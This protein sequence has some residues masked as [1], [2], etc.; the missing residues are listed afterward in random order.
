M[1]RHHGKTIWFT[2]L[3][4]SGKSTISSRLETILESRGVP[5][6]LLDGDLL[7]SGLNRDLGFSAK[8]RAENIRRAGETAKILSDAG[9]TVL[10]AFITPMEALRQAVRGLFNP[11]TFVEVFLSC[12]ISVCEQRDPKGLYSLAR[13][14]KIPEFTGISSPFEPPVN[15]DLVVPTGEQTLE[16]SAGCILDF[17]EKRFSDLRPLSIQARP[18]RS[19]EKRVLVIGLDSVP[20]SLVFGDAGKSLPNLSALVDHGMS[21]TLKSTDPPITVPAWSTMTTG[22]D[23]GELGLYGFRNR[24]SHDYS[25]MGI[26]DATDVEAPRVWDYLE[27]AGN[28]SILVGIPQTYP[29][30]P[31]NGITVCGP[32]IPEHSSTFTFPADLGEKLGGFIGGDY[33]HDLKDFRTRD[34]ARLLD[35]LHVMVER[36]FRLVRH[37]LVHRPWNFFMMVEMATDRL[38]HAFWRYANPDHHLYEAGNPFENVISDFYSRLDAYIGSLLALLNDDTTVMVVSDHGTRTMKGSV[39]INEWLLDNGFLVLQRQPDGEQ[40]LSH[41][42]VDWSRT[43]AW[44]EGGYYAR[45]FLNVKG[46]EPQGTIEPTELTTVKNRLAERLRRISD[47]NGTVVQNVVLKPEEIYRDCRRVP[48]DLIVYFDGLNRRSVGTVGLG[49]IFRTG[50]DTGPDDANHDADGIFIMA[51]MSDLRNGVRMTR[52]IEGASIMDVT[53][54]ILREFGVPVPEGLGGKIIGA[55]GLECPAEKDSKI[56]VPAGPESCSPPAGTGCG[57]S[58]EEQEIIK[59]RL[60]ELGYI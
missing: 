50:N 52:G 58:A 59:K 9:H 49:E 3:S 7:R 21:G 5:V 43:V 55:E 44:G 23:P 32:F 15:S 51:R 38:H 8:D 48:P 10:A 1:K 11:G 56:V 36:R 19:R 17:L 57:Y 54:T 60:A 31:H 29:P 46:R 16:E 42:L 25:E 14:G 4:G 22:K 26:A 18:R 45:V 41:D 33:F 24:T 20:P 12:P 6:V 13:S 47:R 34:R 28:Q 53:P 30:R 35:D 27:K 2:G 39:G 37:F 40:P